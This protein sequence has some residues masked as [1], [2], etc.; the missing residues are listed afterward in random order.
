MTT[1]H[2]TAGTTGATALISAVV[3]TLNEAAHIEPCLRTLRW[4]GEVLVVDCGSTDGTPEL[5]RGQGARVLH[6]AWQGWASQ[7]NFALGEITRPWVF[8]VDADERV[9]AELAREIQAAVAEAE[10]AGTP[11]GFW[12]P[13]QNLILGTWMRY[14]GWSPDYQLRLFRRDR[15]RYDPAR[16]VHELVLLDG[17]DGHLEN[18]LVHH[19]YH[20]WRQLWAKQ[21]RYAREEAAAMHA[22]AVR[23]K[24]QNFV[25]QPVREFR[26]RYWTLEGYRAGRLGLALCTLLAV[27]NF[28]TYVH[29][30]QLNRRAPA[31]GPVPPGTARQRPGEK[32]P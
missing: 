17:A 32:Q 14:A 25:L 7:R 31:G 20:S 13:R 18:R 1:A 26:R 21:C 16:P 22:Q 8:F 6:R 3:L 5:A 28:M 27:A 4:A 19:N 30:W 9:P 10:R 15:G 24:P 23:V 29:L 12:V 11:A 2:Q